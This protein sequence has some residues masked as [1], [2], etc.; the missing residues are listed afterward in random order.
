MLGGGLALHPAD[1]SM[2]LGNS[3]IEA[4]LECIYRAEQRRA[5]QERQ[6]Q[7]K[8]G[9]EVAGR[10]G[11]R[12]RAG[13]GKRRAQ[14]DGAAAAATPTERKPP[15]RRVSHMILHCA[16]LGMCIHVMSFV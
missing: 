16:V 6:R 1:T 4:A 14:S 8:G 11:M 10:R 3:I 12:I 7:K 15:R 5:Q 2:Q 9:A 13:A